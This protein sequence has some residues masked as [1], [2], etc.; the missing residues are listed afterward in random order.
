M[1]ETGLWRLF[2]RTGL[3][4]AWLALRGLQEE[5]RVQANQPAMTA[6]SVQASQ[7]IKS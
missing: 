1:E 2:F 6:F 4:E 5:E 3:P 7:K